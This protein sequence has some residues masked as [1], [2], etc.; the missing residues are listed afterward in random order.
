MSCSP[1]QV[2]LSSVNS[3]RSAFGLFVFNKSFFE[4]Y[5]LTKQHF[6]SNLA[7]S[8][9]AK[10]FQA[11]GPPGRE[12]YCVHWQWQWLTFSTRRGALVPSQVLLAPLKPRSANTI[13][14]CTITLLEGDPDV[15][16]GNESRLVIRL[17]CAHGQSRSSLSPLSL[18][19]L[20][21]HP[22]LVLGR[23]LLLTDRALT[24]V[25]RLLWF[26]E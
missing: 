1:H 24:M 2:K 23:A 12:W 17:H 8:V 21:A 14:S 11:L 5:K 20:R 9:T 3:S 6:H 19:A 16:D 22:I 4:S 15:H 18:A 25:T 26:Q 13:E 7:F 10:V